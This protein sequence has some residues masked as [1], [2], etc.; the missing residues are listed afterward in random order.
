MANN[1]QIGAIRV[2]ATL[3]SGKFV[4]GAKKIRSESQRTEATVKSSFGAMGSA[5]KGFGGALTAG[6]SIGLLGGLAKKALDFAAA[7]G[8]TAKQLGVTTRELQLFRHAADQVGVKNAEADKGLEKLG[9]TLGKAAAGSKTATAA[10]AAVGVSV[11]DINNKS[12]TEIFGKIADGMNRTGGAA[13][14]AAA[15]N[16]IFGES[17]SKLA[18]LLDRGSQGINEL[19]QAAERLGIVLSDDQIQRADETAQ[20][21]DDVR[22]VL[23]AQ[24]AGVVADNASSIVGL[25]NALA[26]LTSSIV[27]FLGSN[28]QAALGI[29]GALAG[30]RFGIPGAVAGGIAG[31]AAGSRVAAGA[32]D[33]NMDPRFRAEQIRKAQTEYARTKTL[34]GGGPAGSKDRARAAKELQRQVD[35]GKQAEA[36]LKR[37]TASAGTAAIPQFLAPAAKSGGGRKR[38]PRAPKDT[39][40]RDAYQFDQDLRRAQMDVLRASQSLVFDYRDRAQFALQILDLE[41]QGYEAQLEYEVASGDISQAQANKLKLLYDENNDLERQGIIRERDQTQFEESVRLNEARGDLARQAL[42]SEQQLA[43]TASEQRT[44]QLRL[45]DLAYQ[46]ERARLEAILADKQASH[47]AQDEARLRLAGLSQTYENDRQGV[48]NSTRGPWEQYLADLPTTAAKWEEALQGVRVNGFEALEQS[49][50]D[51]LTGVKSLGDAFKDVV[52]QIVADLLRLAI[53]KYIVGALANVLGVGGGL[54]GGKGVISESGATGGLYTDPLTGLPAFA[55]GGSFR[56]LGRGGTD[57]NVLS[58]NGMNVARVSH[59]ERIDVSNDNVNGGGRAQVM[60]VPTPY[61]DA[62]VQGQAVAV[63]APMASQAA[64]AGASG[65][66]YRRVQSQRR[67]IP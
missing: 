52:N 8:T 50:M 5:V 29:L 14:N 38:T 32:R 17:A 16:A 31:M 39:S 4:D 54:L 63:A 33:A 11:D 61:F 26:S 10:L 40:L 9:V 25:A 57:R 65:A 55:S 36:A 12:R 45:L 44:I 46:Q 51:T 48:M 19:S 7:I 67:A 23:S 59:G 15:A 47:A 37:G 21:L 41:K 66:E 20:K 56:V 42:Q 13:K 1:S 35:L 28:P 18:P 34:Y 64:G 62:H 49:I 6:L 53:R 27:N 60:I 24:I 58:L 2:E 30:G 22:A 43:E 3:E